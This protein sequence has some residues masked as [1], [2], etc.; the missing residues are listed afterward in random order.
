MLNIKLPLQL[1]MKS[2]LLVLCSTRYSSPSPTS[3]AGIINLFIV[4]E[5]EVRPIKQLARSQATT[6][7]I[8]AGTRMQDGN[9][10]VHGSQEATDSM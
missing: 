6:L 7:V 9:P 10:K 1:L 3:E 5:T 4:E 2:S 8:G